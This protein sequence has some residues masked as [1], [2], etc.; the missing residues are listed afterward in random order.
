MISGSIYAQQLGEE[1]PELVGH[2][3]LDD[4]LNLDIRASE[5]DLDLEWIRELSLPLGGSDGGPLTLES[6]PALWAIKLPVMLRSPQLYA[7][8]DSAPPVA[9]AVASA[10][11]E[12]GPG[13]PPGTE[14]FI[15]SLHQAQ[16]VGRLHPGIQI[17]EG[18]GLN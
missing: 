2:F 18:G 11:A 9:S 4:E 10:V 12:A 15:S 3:A 16:A 14:S 7:E 1:Q 8:V 6:D 17:P 13:K 5:A